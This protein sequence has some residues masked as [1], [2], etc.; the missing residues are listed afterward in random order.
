MRK[1]LKKRMNQD[2][3]LRIVFFRHGQ[4]VSNV[5]GRLQYLE[6]PLTELGKE[7]VEDSVVNLKKFSFDEIIS[8]DEFRAIES[9]EIINKFF[10]IPHIKTSVIREKSSGDFSKKLVSEVNWDIVNGS[11]LT[12]KIPNGESVLDVINRALKFFKFLNKK[13]QG[14]EILIVSHGAFL[15]VL[16]AIIFNKNIRSILIDYKFPNADFF[17][18]TR[19]RDGKWEIESSCVRR[20]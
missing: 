18:L 7:Q 8:S 2:N 12:K 20:K 11:F 15:R 6:D 10:K 3:L 13:N 16:L 9:A 4:T 19:N 17:V 14:E 5:E 1:E